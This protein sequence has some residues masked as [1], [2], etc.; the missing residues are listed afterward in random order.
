MINYTDPTKKDLASKEPIAK[1][2]SSPRRVDKK[3]FVNPNYIP[4][5]KYTP[6]PFTQQPFANLKMA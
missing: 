2:Q 1:I 6:K 5:H 3:G 4:V